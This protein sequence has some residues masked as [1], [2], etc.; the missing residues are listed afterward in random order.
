VSGEPNPNANGDFRK[1]EE[2]EKAAEKPKR[3]HIESAVIENANIEN[4]D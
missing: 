4:G 1:G 2:Q 3:F